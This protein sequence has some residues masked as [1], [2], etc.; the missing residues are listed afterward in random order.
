MLLRITIHLKLNGHLSSDPLSIVPPLL[1]FFVMEFLPRAVRYKL[2][3]APLAFHLSAS[4][5]PSRFLSILD[6]SMH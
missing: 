4:K 1:T 6:Y 2:C 5:L 3:P